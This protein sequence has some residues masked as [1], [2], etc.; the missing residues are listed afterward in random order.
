MDISFTNF[1]CPCAK[2]SVC[3]LRKVKIVEALLD[4]GAD[5]DKQSKS[6]LTAI[7]YAILS[8]D[9][10]IVDLLLEMAASINLIE[11]HFMKEIGIL[12]G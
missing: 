9:I 4:H 7:H 6:G 12:Y 8:G 5:P 1:A 10:V 3:E 2:E 11:K